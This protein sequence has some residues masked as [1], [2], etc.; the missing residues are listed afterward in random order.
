MKINREHKDGDTSFS[1]RE[2][3][4]AITKAAAL[5]SERSQQTAVGCSQVGNPCDR[6]LAWDIAVE[7]QTEELFQP[8]ILLMMS[9]HPKA[10]DYWAATVGTAVHSWLESAFQFDEG[11]YMTEVT[12]RVNGSLELAGADASL[13]DQWPN[14][15]HVTGHVDM[16]DVGLETVWDHKVLGRSSIERILSSGLGPKYHTQTQL[17]GLGMVQA[18]MNI[19]TVGLL[20]WPRDGKSRDLLTV[21]V[22]FDH[23]HATRQLARLN[24]LRHK[25]RRLGAEALAGGDQN[26]L[27]YG[28]MEGFD[29][30][31]DATACRFCPIRQWCPDSIDP[32]WEANPK[33]DA[34]GKV[35]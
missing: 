11:E 7:Q 6:S 5:N 25:M 26:A 33:I 12:I 19:K 16:V 27:R 17:Y 8:G 21:E 1:P 20:I 18:G 13:V 14:E 15:R 10:G 24:V 32:A 35:G 30:Q 9:E 28:L 34:K 4:L 29:A 2:K 22:P 23:G 31:P 3:Y